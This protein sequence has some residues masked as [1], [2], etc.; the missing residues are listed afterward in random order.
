M[1]NLFDEMAALLKR[2]ETAESALAAVREEL[3]RTQASNSELHR[4]VNDWA[5]AIRSVAYGYIPSPTAA[6]SAIADLKAKLDRTR[7]WLNAER[8]ENVAAL[9][10]SRDRE[11][12]LREALR[13]ALTLIDVVDGSGVNAL[14]ECAIERL[15]ALLASPTPTGATPTAPDDESK[16]QQARALKQ[17]LRWIDATP[18]AFYPVRVL[19]AYRGDCDVRS[20]TDTNGGEDWVCK[21]MNEASVDR[22][23]ILDAAIGLLRQALMTPTPTPSAEAGPMQL[24]YSTLD[25]NRDGWQGARHAALLAALRV[26]DAQSEP[27]LNSVAQEIVDAIKVLDPPETFAR[28]TMPTPTP[29]GAQGERTDES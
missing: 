17:E 21:V 27:M 4:N 8:T 9:T 14:P 5:E 13:E 18:D 22:A 1:S 20:Y 24:P 26:R 6:R 15:E 3:R 29:E 11:H 16:R 19:E 25:A 12:E 7:E 28:Y 23:R 10:A 2:A